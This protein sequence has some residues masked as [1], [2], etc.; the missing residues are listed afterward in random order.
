MLIRKTD[1]KIYGLNPEAVREYHKYHISETVVIFV[2]GISF[3]DSIDNVG[4]AIN[5]V[6]QRNQDAKF[7]Q[8]NSVGNNGVIIKDKGDII[9][10]DCN[11][12]ISNDGTSKDPKFQLKMFFGKCLFPV[13]DKLV[14]GGDILRGLLQLSRVTIL[15]CV[16]CNFYRYVVNFCKAK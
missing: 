2:V 14:C 5:L 3:E 1:R 11:I 15:A 6:L 16:I 4:R 13:I 12:T 7:I 8:R 10:A 9:Y